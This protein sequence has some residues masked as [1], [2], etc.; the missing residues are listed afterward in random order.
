MKHREYYFDNAKFIL[1]FF[2]VFGH[3]IRPL[4]EDNELALAIYKVIYTFHMPAFILVSG[5]FAKG[6]QQQ[7]YLQK[8]TKKLIYPYII[9]QVIYSIFYFFLYSKSDLAINFL[10]PQWSLWFLISLL[11]WHMMLLVFVKIKP[12]HSVAIAVMIGLL[13]GYV[14]WVNNF[15]SLSR[16][17]VFFPLFLVGFYLKKEHFYGLVKPKFKTISFILILIVFTT[18]YFYPEMNEKWLLGSKPYEAL[19]NDY[20]MAALKR[21]GIYIISFVMVLSFFSFVPKRKFMFSKLGRNT[22]YV[23]LLHGFFVKLFRVM[24]IESYIHKPG[25]IILLAILSLGLTFIL[26]NKWLT[27]I[28]KPLFVLKIPKWKIQ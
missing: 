19:E 2:V 6:I 16:T 10:K 25:L 12:I 9:F 27:K 20:V 24:S 28:V 8:I 21:L 5:F 22:L 7:G 4:I 3:F 14:G 23:Y 13:I 26:S 18:F 11:F 15:L 17:F 1:I